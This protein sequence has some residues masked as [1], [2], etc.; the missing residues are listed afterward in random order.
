M[1]G[2]HCSLLNC[3]TLTDKK[4][5]IL[6]DLT[7]DDHISFFTEVNIQSPEHLNVLQADET[8]IWKF[9]PKEN[10]FQQRIALRYPAYLK[11]IISFE[12]LKYEYITQERS[13]KDQCCAQYM[14]FR[15]RFDHLDYRVALVYRAPDTDMEVNTS[16]LY[17]YIARYVPHLLVGDVNLDYSKKIMRHSKPTHLIL[18]I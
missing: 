11:D 15:F 7:Q 17:A 12:L 13:Q 10:D 5:D 1:K 3:Q 9:I 16:L 6:N 14:V 18:D 8:Y 2:L 4:L